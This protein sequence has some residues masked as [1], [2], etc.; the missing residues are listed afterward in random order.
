MNWQPISTAPTNTRVLVSDDKG[1]VFIARAATLRW[2]DEADRLIDRPR[3][4]QSLPEPPREE[5]P[6]KPKKQSRK[7]R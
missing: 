3:W 4:W 5:A 7:S 1:N 6:E 2:R